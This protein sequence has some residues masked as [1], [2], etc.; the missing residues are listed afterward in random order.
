VHFQYEVDN[1]VLE[2]LDA[3]EDFVYNFIN[4]MNS[5]TSSF[6]TLTLDE[7][8]YIQ[9]AGSRS[10]MTI[11]IR[12]PHDKGFIHYV[13]GKKSFIK[14]NSRIQ[15]SGGSIQ[16]MSNEVLNQEHSKGIIKAFIYSLEVPK[17]YIKRNATRMFVE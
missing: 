2:E 5:E 7:D 1:H 9:C 14:T 16:L 12:K 10:K 13:V 15:Y 6:C 3:T 8:L 11:E 4:Q 17:E